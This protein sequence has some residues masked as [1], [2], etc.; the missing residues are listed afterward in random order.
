[1]TSSWVP[2]ADSHEHFTLA[3]LPIGV[4]STASAGPRCGVAIGDSILVKNT[5]NAFEVCHTTLTRV[6][7]TGPCRGSKKWFA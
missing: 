1:M 7:S 4:F 5:S 6:C 2:N 3:N